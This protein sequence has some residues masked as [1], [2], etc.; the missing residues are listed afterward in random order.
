MLTQQRRDADWDKADKQL[1]FKKKFGKTEEG[2]WSPEPAK[3][4]SD[5]HAEKE[6]GQGGAN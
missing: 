6:E 4:P 5:H 3:T 1:G 2:P